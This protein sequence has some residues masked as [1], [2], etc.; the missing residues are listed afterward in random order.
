[1]RSATCAV[2][3][4]AMALLHEHQ[5][6]VDIDFQLPHELHL[7]DQIVGDGLLLRLLAAT[8]LVV[9]VEVHALVVLQ[10][11]GVDGVVFLEAVE[12]REDVAQA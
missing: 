7:E 8:Q 5:D 11:P 9:Q 10:F 4:V 1:M 2:H 3:V 12:A 6:V